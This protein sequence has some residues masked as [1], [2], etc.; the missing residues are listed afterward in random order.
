MKIGWGPQTV[1]AGLASGG[2]VLV[3]TDTAIGAYLNAPAACWLRWIVAIGLDGSPGQ[4]A[5]S[6]LR[7]WASAG[8]ITLDDQAAILVGDPEIEEYEERGRALRRDLLQR[9]ALFPRVGTPILA[10]GV[11]RDCAYCDQLLTDLAA[12]AP[13]RDG[14]V[15]VSGDDRIRLFGAFSGTGLD[16]LADLPDPAS[17]PETGESTDLPDLPDL[18]DLPELADLAEMARAAAPLGTPSG[19]LLHPGAPPRILEGYHQVSAMIVSTLG[20]EPDRVVMETP[21]SCSVNVTSGEGTSVRPV[22]AGDRVVG[23]ATRGAVTGELDGWLSAHTADAAYAPATLTVERPRNLYLVYRGGAMIARHRTPADTIACLQ[24]ML[25]GYAD[26]AGAAEDEADVDCGVLWHPAHGAVL[27]P[28]HWL[29]PMARKSSRLRRSG[30][31]LCPQPYVR[32]GMRDGQA[33]ARVRP[34]GE[35]PRMAPVAFLAV[36]PPAP[37][38]DERPAR[39]PST[40]ERAAQLVC[41]AVRPLT[42]PHLRALAA[43]AHHIP[44]RT[45][46]PDPILAQLPDLVLARGADPLKRT[47]AD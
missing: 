37:A 42:P 16:R 6:C 21:S 40:E 35:D 5:L 45:L 15:V 33:W 8:L 24:T 7:V 47:R 31:Q 9:A 2:A 4:A 44:I 17:L 14:G 28:N 12:N 22:R 29:S 46:G 27:I 43:T 18:A 1:L 34:L 20:D 26:H 3:R 32:L 13:L 39:T 36:D 30:W 41:W 11:G 38:I 19:V 10:V 25:A 23:I